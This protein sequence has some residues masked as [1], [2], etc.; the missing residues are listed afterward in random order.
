MGS[1]S[2]KRAFFNQPRHSLRVKRLYECILLCFAVHLTILPIIFWWC[3]HWTKFVLGD[4]HVLSFF[5]GLPFS[6]Q[7]LAESQSHHIRQRLDVPLQRSIH[8]D[9]PVCMTTCERS[10]LGV[11]TGN[12][13]RV[14]NPYLLKLSA[15]LDAWR[16]Y[17]LKWPTLCAVRESCLSVRRARDSRSS[18]ETIWFYRKFLRSHISDVTFMGLGSVVPKPMTLFATWLIVLTPSLSKVLYHGCNV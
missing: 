11:L 2:W 12:S 6:C 8:I 10:S 4:Q 9:I 16:T 7:P 15:K 17:R 14:L 13:W 3:H 18:C 5:S 1:P